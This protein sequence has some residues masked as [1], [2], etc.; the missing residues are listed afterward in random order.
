MMKT[1][2]VELKC[3]IALLGEGGEGGGN[4][5]IPLQT[6]CNG[7]NCGNGTE[8]S[9]CMTLHPGSSPGSSSHRK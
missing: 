6:Q 3:Y 1:E 8:I 9:D 4:S 5:D 2:T 7:T